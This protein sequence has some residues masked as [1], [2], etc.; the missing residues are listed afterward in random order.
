MHDRMKSMTL[1]MVLVIALGLG[2]CGDRGD[3]AGGQ[4]R[5]EPAAE[6]P[7]AV[8]PPQA[9][10]ET[11]AVPE[12]EPG[13]RPAAK[14][15]SFAGFGPA[16]WG[17]SEEQLRMA[18]GKDMRADAADDPDACHYLYPLPRPHAGFGTAFMFEG[19]KLVRIDVD[20]AHVTAPGGGKTGMTADAVRALYPG[21]IEA[22]PHKYVEGGQ[23][24][25][26]TDPG[27]N[28]VLVFSVTDNTVDGWRVGVAPQ[29]DYVEGCA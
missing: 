10:P 1:A 17:A 26:V 12:V 29:V 6:P 15:I 11:P 20:S 22:Q 18:W 9:I 16:A 19:R 24:L 21:R 5:V 2:A 27:S 28:G 13:P 4:A 8:T 14:A 7:V 23:Y 25:R 3:P